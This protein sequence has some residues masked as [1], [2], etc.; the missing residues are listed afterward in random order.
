M[1]ADE[2]EEVIMNQQCC[3]TCDYS[4]MGDGRSKHGQCRRH[5]PANYRQQEFQSC[6]WPSI[7]HDD[8]CGDFVQR[9]RKSSAWY[10]PYE[11]DRDAF[12]NEYLNNDNALLRNI[13]SDHGITVNT[14]STATREQIS[15]AFNTLSR[16]PNM[17]EL[18]AFS[19]GSASS[20][21]SEDTDR[22][23]IAANKQRLS[24]LYPRTLRNSY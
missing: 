5:A 11:I 6:E 9:R 13:F 19:N 17:I 8:W 21:A 12:L 4:V 24:E 7:A 14:I 22:V 10:Y 2:E 23:T 15:D 18:I 3:R 16:I 20:R 1:E